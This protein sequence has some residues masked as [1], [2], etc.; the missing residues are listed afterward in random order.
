MEG[1][2]RKRE[3]GNG[4]REEEEK[5]GKW[6]EKGGRKRGEMEGERRKRERGEMEGGGEYQCIEERREVKD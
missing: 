4:G 6:R 3:R 2:R 5:E 1:E